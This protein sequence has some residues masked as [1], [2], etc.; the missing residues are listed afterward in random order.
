MKEDEVRANSSLKSIST[1]SL[2]FDDAAQELATLSQ[3]D[4]TI[5]RFNLTILDADSK[6][7]SIR[8]TRRLVPLSDPDF[9]QLMTAIIFQF[10]ASSIRI[11]YH[12][13]LQFAVGDLLKR[14]GRNR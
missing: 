14:S 7:A 1:C 4:G 5:Q 12:G 6:P 2:G 3:N 13:N 9:G 8:N 10:G 11:G